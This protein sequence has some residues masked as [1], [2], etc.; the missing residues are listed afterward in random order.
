MH[1]L[2]EKITAGEADAGG[3]GAA[4]GT[5]RPGA[6]HQ[7]VR[8]GP[9]RAESGG[10][11][12]CATSATSTRRTSTAKAVRPESAGAQ[13]GGDGMSA[14]APVQRQDAE[15]D[16]RDVRRA[17]KTDHPEVARENGIFIP[18]LCDL[19]GL[20]QRGRLPPVP[21]RVKGSNKLLPACVTRVEEG[22]EVTVNSERLA[23]YPPDDPG[24][25]VHR[26]QPR[27]LGLRLQ[28]PLRSADRWR[29]SWG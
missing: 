23:K 19:D 9:V 11:A 18:T 8:A 24:T 1:D 6:Q 27:L 17:G 3:P 7:P 13:D 29:R 21:G 14:R 4:R 28:R 25:A 2:L 22:M 20:S 10:R 15:I 16:G 26:A 5:V 12:R